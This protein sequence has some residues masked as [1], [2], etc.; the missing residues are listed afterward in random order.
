MK[1]IV[2]VIKDSNNFLLCMHV[3]PDGDTFGS[4]SAFACMLDILG[5]KFKL[6]C[7]GKIPKIYKSLKHYEDAVSVIPDGEKFDCIVALD[8][9]DSKRIHDWENIKKLSDLIINIDHH[10][11][12]TMFGHINYVR[13]ASST[14]ELM[15]YLSKELGIAINKDMATSLYTSIITDTGSFKYD[16]TTADVFVVVSELVKAGAQPNKIA[17]DVYESKTISEIRVLGRALNRIECEFDEKVVW[18]KLSKK[19]LEETG[20]TNEEINGIVDYLRAIKGTEVAFLLREIDDGKIK[21]NFRSNT[22]NIQ[23][24]AKKLGGGGH[25]KASGAVVDGTL[26][27][28]KN[29]VISTIKELWTEL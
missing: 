23:K 3:D 25:Q 27:H 7:D 29:M 26:R 1:K 17:I 2:D 4:A 22:K 11:D 19:D 13:K 10:G 20:A 9:G 28:V 12:N 5:K 16:N 14:G 21:I 15:Y 8:C 18:V 24:I 6:Y